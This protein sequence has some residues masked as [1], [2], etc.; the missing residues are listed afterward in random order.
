ML[1]QSEI[2]FFQQRNTFHVSQKHV[3]A[4]R[5]APSLLVRN[6]FQPIKSAFSASQKHVS[7]NRKAPSLLVIKFFLANTVGK[8]L[9]CQSET[10]FIQKERTIHASQKH[11][12]SNRKAPFMLVRILFQ[13]KGKH[14]PYQSE[15]FFLQIG[16]QLLCQSKTIINKWQIIIGK[17][18]LKINP[19]WIPLTLQRP[20]ISSKLRRQT[21]RKL[22][23]PTL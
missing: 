13:P 22:V 6:M 19:D 11:V 4:N 8:K 14:L 16:K 21:N 1:Q 23:K 10:R 18:G 15:R 2:Y 7:S 17:Q 9:L 12:S 5:K 20:Q 3:S